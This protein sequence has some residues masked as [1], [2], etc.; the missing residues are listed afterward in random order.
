MF[1][2]DSSKVIIL[3]LQVFFNNTLYTGSHTHYET[4]S[5]MSIT[6][7]IR[8][9]VSDITIKDTRRKT[10]KETDLLQREIIY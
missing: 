7:F 10:R 2:F 8:Q 5:R 9:R 3:L 4:L 6:D 1:F